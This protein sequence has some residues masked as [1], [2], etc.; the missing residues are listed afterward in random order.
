MNGHG[1]PQ[2]LSFANIGVF[3]SM[4]FAKLNNC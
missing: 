3:L 1:E 4:I 2:S